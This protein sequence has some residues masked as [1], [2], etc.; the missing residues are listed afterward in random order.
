MKASKVTIITTVIISIGTG[1]ALFEI[2]DGSSKLFGVIVGIFT[3][4]LITLVS[5]LVTYLD[6]RAAIY[7]VVKSNIAN[8][9]VNLHIIHSMTGNILNQIQHVYSFN[10]LNYKMIVGLAEL[11]IDF[12]S[13][14]QVS[15]FEPIF[16]IGK[17][18]NAIEDM[19]EFGDDLFN[20][21]LCISKIQNIAFEHD[22]ILARISNRNPTAD[23][24]NRLNELR[25]LILVQTAKVHEY[26]ASLMLKIDKIAMQ[27]YGKKNNSWGN[28]KK[29]LLIKADS[30]LK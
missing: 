4:A 23:E 2:Q 20:L 14:M 3:G 13:G 27:F 17:K 21:K 9:Y 12:A 18:C 7:Q 11:N 16:S 19:K 26:Q 1:V 5:T 25:T 28:I 29:E 30:I 8:I 22:L 15:M 6:K 10:E 24:D